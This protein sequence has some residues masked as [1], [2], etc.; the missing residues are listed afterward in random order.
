MPQLRRIALF[1][2]D[3]RTNIQY[4]LG[5]QKGFRQLGI[6]CFA[7]WNLPSAESLTTFVD[8]WQPDAILEL[9]RTRNHIRGFRER[10]PHLAWLEADQVLGVAINEGDGGS[11]IVYFMM[12]P[13]LLGY[14]YEAGDFKWLFPGADESIFHPGVDAPFVFDL[15]CAG[16]IPAPLGTDSLKRDLVLRG[17]AAGT[18]EDLALGFI[19]SGI[20]CCRDGASAIQGFLIDYG[21]RFLA[22]ITLLDYPLEARRLVQDTLPRLSDRR[23]VAE[24]MLAASTRSAFFG[25]HGWTAWR[26]LAPFYKGS[27]D[28][29]NELAKAYRASRISVHNSFLAMHSRTMEVM[30]C[31]RP[32]LVNHGPTDRDI[33]RFFTPGEDFLF[34][35][36]ETLADT[37]RGA[38]ADHAE[39]A[40]I[41]RNAAAKIRD[42]HTWRHRAEQISHDYAAL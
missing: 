38:L 13:A 31:G 12:E 27:L 29:Q 16:H 22:D 17:V 11:D 14:E 41:G 5:L 32:I 24:Q 36:L 9:N 21:R 37:A 7:M 6:E 34:Y 40:R 25:Y 20:R 4:L 26:H 15:S 42:G 30:A 18:L 10:I 33:T 23:F 39:L 19:A 1:C 2:Q 3:F 28:R 8:N 35:D